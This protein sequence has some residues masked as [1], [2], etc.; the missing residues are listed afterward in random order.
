MQADWQGKGETIVRALIMAMSAAV[1]LGRS[2]HAQSDHYVSGYTKQDGTIGFNVGAANIPISPPEEP[3]P[4]VSLLCSGVESETNVR[5]T[6]QLLI[7]T[8]NKTIRWNA[9]TVLAPRFDSDRVSFLIPV[10][11]TVR[12]LW[13]IRSLG[14]SEAAGTFKQRMTVERAT[15][16]FHSAESSGICQPSAR[17]TNLF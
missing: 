1:L 14:L 15:G 9:L 6:F 12:A 7:D 17:A 8:S 16:A 11:K 5:F 4:Q 2:A 10:N 3:A 13:A